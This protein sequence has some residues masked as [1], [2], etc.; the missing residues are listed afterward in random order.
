[1]L[2]SRYHNAAHHEP[3]WDVKCSLSNADCKWGHFLVKKADFDKL[4]VPGKGG[5][6]GGKRSNSPKANGKA[7]AKAK[8]ETKTPLTDEERA[9][10]PCKGWG[11][12]NCNKGDQCK[13]EHAPEKFGKLKKKK[14]E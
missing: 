11:R 14:D 4:P 9:K 1:M 10:I 7:K 3:S 2:V 13:F 8:S 12:G 5:G 6:K